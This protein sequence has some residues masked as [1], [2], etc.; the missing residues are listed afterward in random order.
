MK[1]LDLK[2]IIGII[3]VILLLCDLSLGGAVFAIR[4]KELKNEL[5]DLQEL[6][7][8]EKLLREETE[9]QLEDSE[10][11][12]EAQEKAV[13]RPE[14]MILQVE[15]ISQNP[16]LPNGCEITSAAE[17]LNYWGYDVDKLTLARDFLPKGEPY[18]KQDPE[19]KYMGDPE[20]E[21]YGWYCF[22]G[23][24]VEAVNGYFAAV[25]DDKMEALDI[26]GVSVEELKDCIVAGHPVIFWATQGFGYIRNRYEFKLPDGS[27]PYTGLHC[28]VLK[29]YDEENFY[30]ADPLGRNEKVSIERFSPIFEG[31]G[32]RAVLIMEK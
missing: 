9:K 28:M 7:T 29:G 15:N 11:Q 5:S 8:E 22:T 24:V 21:G 3:I 25:N 1:K 17:V 10:N 23:P 16:E 20:S 2:N 26:S 32:R 19:E 27:F 30:I 12:R 4:N 14:K 31:L 13:K 18:Y 6:Y